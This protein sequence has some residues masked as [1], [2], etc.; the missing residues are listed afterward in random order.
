VDD[1]HDQADDDHDEQRKH[2]LDGDRADGGSG[3][4]FFDECDFE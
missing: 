2:G 1:D 4:G 3:R